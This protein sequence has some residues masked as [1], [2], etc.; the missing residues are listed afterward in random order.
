MTKNLAIKQY[1]LY[2]K[3]TQMLSYAAASISFDDSTGAPKKAFKERN[4]VLNYFQSILFSR[5]ISKEYQLLIANLDK[6]YNSLSSKYKRI[7]D[8]SKKEL[9][10][11]VKVPVDVMNKYQMACSEA[12]YY[13]DIAKNKS[14]YKI[15][16]P[17]LEKVITLQKEVGKYM[18]DESSSLYD[19]F[20]DM[21]EEGI[22]T[23]EL[24]VFFATLKDRI[25]PLLKK[26]INS[27]VT[28]NDSFLNRKIN[29]NNQMEMGIL[30][31]KK[32]GYDF[33]MGMVRESEHPFTNGISSHDIRITTHI[34]EN[35][36]ISNLFSMAHEGGHGIYEQNIN[37]R[38]DGSILKG[39]ASLAYHESQSRFFEN[40]VARSKPFSK[41]IFPLLQ[42]KANGVLDDISWEEYYLAIN[43]VMPSLIR[44]EADELTYCLHVM[45]RYEIEK[46]MMEDGFDFDTLPTLWN[47]KYKEYLGVDVPSDKEGVLQDVHWTSGVGYFFSYA[48]G[49][50]YSAQI[51]NAMKKDLDVDTLLESGN[52][53]PIINWLKSHMY[54]YGCTLKP[55]E[56][57]KAITNEQFNPE[58][59]CKYLEEKYS[60]IYQL[61]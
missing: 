47:Q 27:N 9:A 51:Y 32:V 8:I 19:T 25:V 58:Y 29:K 54:K 21:Y 52:T 50:A 33:T 38:L 18:K 39:A 7:V 60:K 13:W 35:N 42:R 36:F 56:L 26:I 28:I 3:E 15:Y 61:D 4:E 46:M 48:L 6:Y 43:K 44:T 20:L 23:A 59:Y 55:K 41:Y 57:I 5:S 22:T 40:I 1:N 45:V 16:K 12:F 17:Y 53:K 10:M 49:N 24:D 30:M 2:M 14:D 31:A 34:Y 37:K 11:N